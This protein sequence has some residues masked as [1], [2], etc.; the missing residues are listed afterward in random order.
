MY[1]VTYLTFG[2]SPY[3]LILS[4]PPPVTAPMKANRSK[5]A[6][7]ISGHLTRFK[8]QIRSHKMHGQKVPLVVV[9]LD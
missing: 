9:E 8:R 1:D 5:M 2:V 3:K 7:R 4:G 6:A